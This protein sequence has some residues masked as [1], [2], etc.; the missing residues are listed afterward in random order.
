MVNTISQKLYTKYN[1][2]V[3]VIKTAFVIISLKDNKKSV[4]GGIKL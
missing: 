1:A 4:V 2:Y 3:Q